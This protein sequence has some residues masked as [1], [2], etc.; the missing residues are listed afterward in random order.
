[1]AIKPIGRTVL[2]RNTRCANASLR[3]ANQLHN[4]P[5]VFPLAELPAAMDAAA[6]AG[7]LESVVVKP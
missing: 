2:K 5:N 6:R 1:M 3:G 4:L 7:N